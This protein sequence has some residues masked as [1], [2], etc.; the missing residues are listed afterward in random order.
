MVAVEATEAEY[1]GLEE[2]VSQL[3]EEKQVLMAKLAE[4]ARDAESTQAVAARES[5]QVTKELEDA[6][7]RCR[8]LEA[9][10]DALSASLSLARTEV[11][12]QRAVASRAKELLERREEEDQAREAEEEQRLRHSEELAGLERRIADA[13]A[14]TAAVKAAEAT[15]RQKVGKW[16]EEAEKWRTQAGQLEQELTQKGKSKEARDH[17]ACVKQDQLLSIVTAAEQELADV[18]AERDALRAAVGSGNQGDGRLVAEMAS[19]Q[20]QVNEASVA[21]KEIDADVIGRM[22]VSP[23]VG[24]AP[25]EPPWTP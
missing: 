23:H 7:S 14:E 20:R 18:M 13:E 2:R 9:S 11:T 19:L 21:C 8:Q 5:R 24:Y 1:R 25:D 10:N 17:D 16:Q 15:L 22:E 12:A 6:K 4:A 3:E